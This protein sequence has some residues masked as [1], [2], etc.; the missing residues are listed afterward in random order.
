VNFREG[1]DPGTGGGR[2]VFRRPLPLPGPRRPSGGA[3]MA[4]A[5]SSSGH[6]GRPGR[7]S[8]DAQRARIRRGRNRARPCRESERRVGPFAGGGQHHRRRGKGPPCHLAPDGPPLRGL[9]AGCHPALCSGRALW[10]LGR[11]AERGLPRACRRSMVVGEPDAGKPPVRFDEGALVSRHV[12]A[13]EA[14]PDERGG[15][16]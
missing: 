3:G 13:R 16:S 10:G 12:G 6:H 1:V 15:N 8:G 2:P 5:D 11:R 4:C 9:P 7:V 14:P